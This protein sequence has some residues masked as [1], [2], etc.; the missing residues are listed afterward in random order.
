M[1]TTIF[2]IRP[3]EHLMIFATLVHTHS[4]V[5][6]H[7]CVETPINAMLELYNWADIGKQILIQT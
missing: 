3:D 4:N 2:M 1:V 6:S 7:G 5:Y